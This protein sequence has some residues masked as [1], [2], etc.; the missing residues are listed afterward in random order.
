LHVLLFL[1]KKLTVIISER[2]MLNS[3]LKIFLISLTAALVCVP[4]TGLAF[5]VLALIGFW[6]TATTAEP[7]VLIITRSLAT[8]CTDQRAQLLRTPEDSFQYWWRRQLLRLVGRLAPE[9]ICYD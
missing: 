5:I 2:S 1:S 4:L 3:A 6:S 8:F 9:R 7:F